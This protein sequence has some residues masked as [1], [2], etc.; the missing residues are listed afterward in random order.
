MLIVL[1]FKIKTCFKI[2]KQK[3]WLKGGIDVLP[4]KYKTQ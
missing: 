1:G 3:H 2:A 4:I